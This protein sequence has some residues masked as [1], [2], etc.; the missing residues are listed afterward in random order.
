MC[1]KILYIITCILLILPN[2][3]I[4][5]KIFTMN[6]TIKLDKY[7]QKAVEEDGNI[8][9]IAGAGAG[10]T[11]TITKKIE[12]LIQIINKFKVEILS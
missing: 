7:Q 6:E 5:G 11:L 2:K 10:K 9:L 4:F 8:L 1:H 12:Y 3:K